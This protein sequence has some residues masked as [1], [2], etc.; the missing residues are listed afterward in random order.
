M[1]VATY[2][3]HACIGADGQF[4]PARTVTVLQEINADVVA[5][6]E[7]EHH[8]YNGYD[9]LDYLAAE[10]GLTAIAGPT[11]LRDTRHYGNA[12]LTRLPIL[13]VTRIDLSL[14][15]RE[16]RGALDV[17]LD[18]HGQRLQVV[19]THLGLRPW[20]R[21]HQIQQLLSLFTSGRA[22]VSVLL[23]DINEWLLWGRPLRWLHRYFAASP[24]PRTYPAQFPLF[25]MDR[26]W[27]HPR[28]ILTNL[29]VHDSP[30]T[31]ITSDHLPLKAELQ[32]K[33]I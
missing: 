29:K 5:L 26:I 11:L 33:V 16:P 8:I 31:E 9:L 18:W 24:Q 4:E 20:E 6:Q 10:T 3:I 23:G 22:D 17:M 19:A 12:I 7:V 28:A 27:V 30:L 21:R 25:A 15:R 14:P 1:R 2:N 32:N 13:A